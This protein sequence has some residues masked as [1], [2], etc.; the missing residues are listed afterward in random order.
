VIERP[1]RLHPD[2]IAMLELPY[3]VPLRAQHLTRGP[4][5]DGTVAGALRAFRE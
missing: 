3:A 5:C 1:P 2:S 4:E